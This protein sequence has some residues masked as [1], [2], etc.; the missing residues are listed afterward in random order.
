M[1]NID[2]SQLSPPPQNNP[3]PKF[4]NKARM[5]A[6]DTSVNIVLDVL[7]SAIRQDEEINSILI[8]KERNLYS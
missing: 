7:A 6:L 5:S 8:G 4:V 2:P 1:K 3:S